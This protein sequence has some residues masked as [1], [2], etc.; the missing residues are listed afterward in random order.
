MSTVTS[1]AS[2][3]DAP[4]QFSDLGVPADLIEVLAADGITEPFPVQV[5]TIPDALAGLDVCGKAPTGSG[6]TLAFGLPVVAHVAKAQPGRPQVLIL[7]PTRELANQIKEQLAPLAARRRRRVAAIYGGVGYGPQRNALRN[8]TDILVACPG[9][10]EDLLEQGAL[11]LDDVRTVV[12][13]EADRMADMGF[14]PAV[15]RLLD[16]TPSDRQTILFSATLDGDVAVLTSRYQ[17]DPVF[18]D[19]AG[20]EGEQGPVHHVFWRMDMTDRLA[21]T[22][23]LVEG[24]GSTVVFART[25]HGADRITRDLGRTGV[26]AAAL[27]GSRSQ[28]QRQKALN[29]FAAGKV[30]A[31]V[32]TDVVARGIHVDDVACVIHFDPPA[33]SKTYVH[34]SGRTARAGAA[35]LVVSLVS[36]DQ[37]V[38]ARIMQRDLDLPIGHHE[39]DIPGLVDGDVPVPI[40][41]AVPTGRASRSSGRPNQGQR[42]GARQGGQGQGARQGGQGAARVREG[43][44][45]GG[46]GQGQ[47]R[48]GQGRG[49]SASSWR[50]SSNRTGDSTSSP[51]RRGRSRASG[52][53]S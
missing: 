52:S 29:D 5:A 7:A 30:S 27:H 3:I 14:L 51:G 11:R 38:E 8:G 4:T 43:A 21:Y 22:A 10:L 36:P 31:L 34:R 46:Q 26:R 1:P 15:K 40:P 50:G 19:V 18:Y 12:I 16:L 28:S 9:R 44:R 39:I 24:I 2:I 37:V 33:D 6:K 42:Q 32:A 23:R 48:G 53:S 13:D 25:R 45:Q 41:E 17:R 49:A 47:G 20:V 35:G